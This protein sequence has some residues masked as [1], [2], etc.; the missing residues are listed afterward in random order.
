MV[1][2][3]AE[4]MAA[5]ESGAGI[6]AAAPEMHGVTTAATKMHSCGMAYTATTEMHA[7]AMTS[8]SAAMAAAVNFNGQTVG[9]SVRC[10]CRAGT[11]QRQCF[12]ALRGR[13]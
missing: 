12:R 7:A 5:I 13:R 4:T 9:G 2:E 11:E 8:A 1:S 3:A 10:S 6:I